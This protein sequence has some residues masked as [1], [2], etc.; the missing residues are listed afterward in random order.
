VSTPISIVFFGTPSF[1]V[2]CAQALTQSPHYVIKAIVTQPDRAAGRGKKLTPS[3]VKE[4]ALTQQIPVLQPNSVRKE[5]AQFLDSLSAH[6][7]FDI[8]VVVAFGQILPL[9]ILQL[10]KAGCINVHASILPRWRGAAPIQRAILQNDAESGICLMQMEAGLDTGPVF[11]EKRL[12]LSSR[13]SFDSLHDKLASLGADA[14][15]RHLSEIACGQIL[16]TPQSAVGVTYAEKI[17]NDEACLDWS[18]SSQE[19]DCQIRALSP[20]PG[21]FTYFQNLRL[22]IFSAEPIQLS[23]PIPAG[24]LIVHEG[25]AVVSCGTHALQLGIIQLE[26]KKRTSAAEFLHGMQSRLPQLLQSTPSSLSV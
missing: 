1:A 15:V 16:A 5:Q 3:P 23:L 26:G 4:F 17:R 8:G 11:I 24:T 13:E 14:L 12:T 20:V 21:A 6:G 7:P 19:L 25:Q 9:P 2:T 22:K 18:R 10:P